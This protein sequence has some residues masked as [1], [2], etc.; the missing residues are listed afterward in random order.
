[1]SK[2]SGAIHSSLFKVI[3]NDPR[4]SDFLLL[5]FNAVAVRDFSDWSMASVAVDEQRFLNSLLIFKPTLQTT[6]Q[7]G[8]I[9]AHLAQSLTN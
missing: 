1:M 9:N 7:E 8:S 4:H 5:R 6:L 3:E 2:I